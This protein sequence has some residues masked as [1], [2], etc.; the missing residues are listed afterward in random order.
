MK[1]RDFDCALLYAYRAG[2]SR[3]LGNC[4]NF[5]FRSRGIIIDNQ[6]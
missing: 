4:Q 2:G 6:D 3:Q 1:L 5:T